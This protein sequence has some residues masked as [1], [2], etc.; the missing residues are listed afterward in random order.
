M[1]FVSK[2]EALDAELA[3][4]LIPYT[5]E[6]LVRALVKAWLAACQLTAA[7]AFSIGLQL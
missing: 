4:E 5:A 3:A 1:S 2:M 7:V 6:E